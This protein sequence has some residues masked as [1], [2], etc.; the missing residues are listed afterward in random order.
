M[1]FATGGREP[2]GA[3]MQ[4]WGC[5]TPHDYPAL[6]SRLQIEMN[7]KRLNGDAVK[8]PFRL[9]DGGAAYELDGSVVRVMDEHVRPSLAHHLEHRR[10]EVIDK[11][12]PGRYRALSDQMRRMGPVADWRRRLEGDA[13]ESMLMALWRLLIADILLYGEDR[14][15]WMGG[16]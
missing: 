9:L 10:S 12:G 4:R 2:V 13:D 6:V 16:S 14:P 15:A 8:R 7:Q 3:L 11:I 5:Q 1:Q